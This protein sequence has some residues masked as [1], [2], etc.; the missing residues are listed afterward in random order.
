[1]SS[2]LPSNGR[3]V[4]VPLRGQVCRPDVVESIVSKGDVGRLQEVLEEVA[5]ASVRDTFSS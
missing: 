4:A 5:F 3:L 2:A 1:M